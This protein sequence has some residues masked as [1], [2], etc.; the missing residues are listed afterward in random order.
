VSIN[1]NGEFKDFKRRL[2]PKQPWLLD[3]PRPAWQRLNP[4][5]SWS[6]VRE[7]WLSRSAVWPSKPICRVI[8]IDQAHPQTPAKSSLP[9]NSG[10]VMPCDSGETPPRGSQ[11]TE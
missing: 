6:A 7:F 11:K 10:S 1:R 5:F 8:P 2:D 4:G 9:P 3:D